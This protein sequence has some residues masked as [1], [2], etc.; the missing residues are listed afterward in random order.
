MANRH[1]H[2]TEEDDAM[3]ISMR[4]KGATVE[5]ISA[6]VG[7]SKSA[8]QRRLL[9]LGFR[10]LKTIGNST[11]AHDAPIGN[12]GWVA[13]AQAGSARLLAALKPLLER[14]AA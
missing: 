12:D 10:K 14:L 5:E 8:V 2:W 7:R 13:D 4:V 9:R 1:P 11:L 6:G 3:V